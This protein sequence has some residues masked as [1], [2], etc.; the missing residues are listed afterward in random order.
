M[1]K[2]LEDTINLGNTFSNK[3]LENLKKVIL[4]YNNL[5]SFSIS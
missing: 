3:R 4:F 2:K 5:D 1:S